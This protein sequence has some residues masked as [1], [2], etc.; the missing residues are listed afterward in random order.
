MATTPKRMLLQ[1]NLGTSRGPFSPKIKVTQVRVSYGL[2]PDSSFFILLISSPSSSIPPNFFFLIY[3]IWTK[4]CRWLTFFSLH[5]HDVEKVGPASLYQWKTMVPLVAPLSRHF[6]LSSSERLRGF[7]LFKTQVFFS[8]GDWIFFKFHFTLPLCWKTLGWAVRRRLHE[9]PADVD[10]GFFAS[11]GDVLNLWK[12]C[13]VGKFRNHE[14]M[15]SWKTAG[16]ELWK[17]NWVGMG[18]SKM[19]LL[20]RHGAERHIGLGGRIRGLLGTKDFGRKAT[21]RELV[22]LHLHPW[23]SGPGRPEKWKF[24]CKQSLHFS[25][26]ASKSYGHRK[27]QFFNKFH[28]IWT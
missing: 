16:R 4:G 13:R 19:G 5:I 22:F 18:R 17:D 15:K 23:I 9:D 11:F 7:P 10:E 24:S 12:T 28:S 8:L 6:G 21:G 25:W 1:V 2:C 3:L 14:I 27:R 20:E 26:I